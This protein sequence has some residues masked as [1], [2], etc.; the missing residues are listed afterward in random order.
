MTDLMPDW[1]DSWKLESP[2]EDECD[3][4][5]CNPENEDE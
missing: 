5:I 1:Y 2:Y 3:C 4:E